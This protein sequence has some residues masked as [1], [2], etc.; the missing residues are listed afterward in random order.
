ILGHYYFVF[1]QTNNALNQFL[2]VWERN[3]NYNEVNYNL[4]ITYLEQGK[5]KNALIHI[6]NE[7]NGQNKPDFEMQLIRG[8]I[9]V[10]MERWDLATECFSSVPYNKFGYY[11]MELFLSALKNSGEFED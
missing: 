1:G 2:N 11:E 6:D 8:E 7:I 3:P 10:K 5:F 9:L 4:A